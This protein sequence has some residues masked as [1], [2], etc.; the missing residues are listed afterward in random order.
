VLVL[1]VGGANLW[2]SWD[3]V[4]SFKEQLHAQQVAEQKAAAKEIGELCDTFGKVALLQPPA[5]NP[6]TN[7]S[8]AFDQNLHADLAGVNPDLGCSRL[9]DKP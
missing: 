4:H 2:G 5:G 6:K 3:Q 8:R 9:G 1:I 7:P